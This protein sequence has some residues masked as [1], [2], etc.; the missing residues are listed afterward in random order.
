M[1]L[2]HRAGY[3]VEAFFFSLLVLIYPGEERVFVEETFALEVTFPDLSEA[4]K[5]EG[6]CVTQVTLSFPYPLRGLV[7]DEHVRAEAVGPA[8][9]GAVAFPIRVQAPRA[10]RLVATEPAVCEAKLERV[11]DLVLPVE[12]ELIGVMS[13]DLLE[14]APRAQPSTVA[15]KAPRQLLAKRPR[16]VVFVP[17]EQIKAGSTSRFPVYLLTQQGEVLRQQVTP[18]A[19]EVFLEAAP[20]FSRLLPVRYKLDGVFPGDLEFRGAEVHP[21]Y[22]EVK[23]PSHKVLQLDEVVTEPIDASRIGFSQRIRAEL[24]LPAGVEAVPAKVE[25]FV[26]VRPLPPPEGEEDHAP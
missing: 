26:S 16:A 12:I 5:V 24:D 9:E 10:T 17:V 6:G 4:W 22:V 13:K 7:R 21:A 20:V 14:T 3:L 18:N 1:T 15:L 8:E 11:E 19:V 2:W 23:G 25:V